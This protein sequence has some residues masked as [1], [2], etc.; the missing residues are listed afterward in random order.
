MLKILTKKSCIVSAK[1]LRD[2]I[3][4]T[5]GRRVLVTTN[6]LK[7]RRGPFIRYGN[8]D[9]VR[10]QDTQ[11]NS[12][13]FIRTVADKGAF[14]LLMDDNDIYS[15]VYYRDVMP[16]NFPV[17]I[18]KTLTGSGGAGIVVCNDRQTF[19][20]HWNI[21]YVW[22]PFVKTKFE[23]RAHIL[24]GQVVKLFKKVPQEGTQETDLPI[25]NLDN[26]YHFQIREI[27]NY[28]KIIELV[29]RLRPILKGEFY[30]LDLGW[31]REAQEYF[32][33]EANSGSGLNTQTVELYSDYLIDKLN[34]Q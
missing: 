18:R 15:P 26:G 30:T 34:L 21:A 6:A 7:I 27:E 25:R 22:T 17:I 19:D 23:L 14:S 2:S 24:G 31:N 33:F 5:T 20:H 29:D 9:P 8:A 3:E 32:I 16:V 12:A 13:E 28:P 10:I 4:Y 11:F 1:L